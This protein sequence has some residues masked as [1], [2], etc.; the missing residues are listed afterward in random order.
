MA[1]VRTLAA[2]LLGVLLAGTMLRP[3]AQEP[4]NLEASVKAAFLFRFAGFVEWPAGA[5][6]SLDTPLV[7]SVVE[8]RGIAGELE[9][10]AASRT[11]DGRPIMVR[12]LGGGEPVPPS[13]IVFIADGPRLEQAIRAVPGAALVVT[14][15]EGAL[16]AGSVI[17]FVVSEGRVRFEVDRDAA[18]RRGLKLSSRMLA[19]A[20]RVTGG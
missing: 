19:V 7:I 20:L 11:F 2:L 14:D 13:H 5:F 4:S 6:P 18:A 9:A 12:R 3:A 10:I 1:P 17:N 15:T 8:H 16:R